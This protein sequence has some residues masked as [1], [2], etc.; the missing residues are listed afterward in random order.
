MCRAHLYRGEVGDRGRELGVDDDRAVAALDGHALPEGSPAE[1][2][3]IGQ[4]L[5][6]RLVGWYGDSIITGRI[7][8]FANAA[9]VV[10]GRF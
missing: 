3:D 1:R 10:W 6:G 4:I 7:T 5:A 9:S 8:L 2:A